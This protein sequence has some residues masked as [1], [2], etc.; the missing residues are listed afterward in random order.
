MKL[1]VLLTLALFLIAPA[2]FGAGYADVVIEGSAGVTVQGFHGQTVTYMT[3]IGCRKLS[4][5]TD[6]V[7]Y[8]GTA[9]STSAVGKVSALTIGYP[10]AVVGGVGLFQA[11]AAGRMYGSSASTSVVANYSTSSQAIV[12]GIAF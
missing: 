8:N 3:E 10:C 2:A 5:L 12:G 6:V 7:K 9:V 1:I 4:S 11:N